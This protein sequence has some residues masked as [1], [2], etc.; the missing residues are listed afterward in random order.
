MLHH[1]QPNRKKS[2]EGGL[3]P[4]ELPLVKGLLKAGYSAQDIVHIINQGRPTTINLAR[5]TE[6]K[7]NSKASTA[8]DEAIKTFLRVQSAYDPKT[9][10]NPYKDERI[11]RAREAM[12]AA[13]QIFNSPTILFKSEVFCVLSNIAWT[14]LLHEK[15]ER[16]KAGSSKLANGNS[17]TVGGTLDKSICPIKNDAVKENLRKLAEIRDAI[18]HT[19]FVGGDECFGALFQA[20]CINFERHMTDWFG[21]HLSLSKELSLALQFV[22][23]QK[24]QVATVEASNLPQKIKA[25]NTAIQDNPFANDNAFQFHV[26]YT[27]E[28]SSKTSADVHQLVTYESGD[29]AEQIA[30]KKLNYTKLSQDDV[31]KKVRA[32]GFKKFGDHDHLLFWRSK[33]PNKEKRNS[34]ATS[35]G[36][37]VLKN[38][39]QWYEQTWLPVVLKYCEDAG[40]KFK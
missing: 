15:L 9:L 21:E 2:K 7:N 22:R 19:Y 13:V 40:D 27:A 38:Q 29:T 5:V 11:I 37:I 18:E 34:E 30:I 36:E 24:S 20:N 23:L 3:T 1:I 16:T 8:S 26:Y 14:Y 10:L 6:A 12:M 33:W 28:A 17:V 39:W 4:E 25:I 32:K 31:V 35:Y